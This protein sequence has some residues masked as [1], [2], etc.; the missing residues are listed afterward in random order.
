MKTG[1]IVRLVC[2][3]NDRQLITFGTTINEIWKELEA[4]AEFGV[5]Q[6]FHEDLRKYGKENFTTDL[7]ATAPEIYLGAL[8]AFWIRY[9]SSFGEDGYH[10]KPDDVFESNENEVD[11][12]YLLN[13]N[14][15]V[16]VPAGL[17]YDESRTDYHGVKE[18]TPGRF[19][20]FANLGGKFTSL[21]IYDRAVEAA[22]A[23]DRAIINDK[24]GKY[25]R[26]LNFPRLFCPSEI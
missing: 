9:F 17:K 15:E 6:P 3:A 4:D 5:K 14:D 10:D 13:L 22:L 8:E 11:V 21:G 25:K 24:T 26:E 19:S 18:R 16:R 23:R 12:D 1:V 20:A 7:L 2:L